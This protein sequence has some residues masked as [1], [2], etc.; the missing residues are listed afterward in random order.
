MMDDAKSVEIE[1][2]LLQSAAEVGWSAR[3]LERLREVREAMRVRLAAPVPGDLRPI[4]EAIELL[5]EAARHAVIREVIRGLEEQE[6]RV[7]QELAGKSEETRAEARR[8]LG[9]LEGK[10]ND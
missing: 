5:G 6:R 1:S 3:C 4:A 9:R 7:L 8:A 10:S 2:T